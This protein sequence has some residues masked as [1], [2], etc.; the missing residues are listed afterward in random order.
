MERHCVTAGVF[1]LACVF[2]AGYWLGFDHGRAAASM[3]VSKGIL[4]RRGRSPR[5]VYGHTSF[6]KQAIWNI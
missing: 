2:V 5:M 4:R 3:P 1:M 6:G